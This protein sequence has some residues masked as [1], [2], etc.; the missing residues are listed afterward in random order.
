MDII[1][2]YLDASTFPLI[3][4]NS[5][6][7]VGSILRTEL[8]A[9]YPNTFESPVLTVKYPTIQISGI[10][11]LEKHT[12]QARSQGLTIVIFDR[13]VCIKIVLIAREKFVCE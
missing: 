5:V 7:Q 11:I 12:S 1:K 8:E 13:D 10:R 6:D 9:W 4:V 3:I 2:H